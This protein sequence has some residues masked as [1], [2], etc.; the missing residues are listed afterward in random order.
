MIDNDLSRRRVLRA[1]GAGGAVGVAG[2]TGGSEQGTPT[3]G[4][5]R[6]ETAT[7]D[8]EELEQSA[9]IA[10]KS[11]PTADTWAVYGG[12]MPYYS[13]CFEPLMWVTDEMGKQPWLAKSWERTGEKTFVFTLRD[14]I[15]FHNG[16]PLTADEVVWSFE[17]ILN[18]WTW[19]SG[20][21]HIT[22]EGVRKVD[23]MTVEF[24]TTDV[25]PTFPGGITHRLAAIQHPDRE[26]GTQPIGTGPF[27]VEDVRKGQRVETSAFD[28]YWRGAPATQNLT[29]RAM[30]DANTRSL[31]L[32][33]NK[34]D[35]A[36]GLPQNK[37]DSFQKSDKT[38]VIT[39]LGTNAAWVEIH[40]K[41]APTDDVK[42]RKALN[43][44]VSQEAI[45]ENAL[46]GLGQPARGGISPVIYWSAHDVLPEYGPDKEKARELVDQSTYNGETL[47]MNAIPNEPVNSKLTA[48]VIQQAA[49]DIGVDISISMMKDATFDAALNDG[50]GHLFLEGGFG[51]QA[52]AAD[53]IIYDYYSEHDGSNWYDQGDEFDALILEGFQTSDKQ[54][55]KE[56]YVKAQKRM[57]EEAIIIPLYY[58]EYTVGIQ[59][60]IEGLVLFP[61]GS[62]SRWDELKHLK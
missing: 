48:Q 11:D 46:A 52:A 14:G 57:M 36:F 1:L 50:D 42:L 22:P 24:T 39:R 3:A 23:D 9:T 20:W 62:M 31:A 19:A 56:A 54:V 41:K 47:K 32:K 38:D 28:D 33:G 34:I 49:S 4:T 40:T 44:A 61:I 59:Q 26:R 17:T 18:E 30:A 7:S 21:L 15:T 8:T 53:Y 27:K 13:N 58:K 2:C 12:V 16:E 60:D 45:V 29:F 37:V 6:D 35:V 10:L 5:P 51:A 43:Y 25:Y 55:K